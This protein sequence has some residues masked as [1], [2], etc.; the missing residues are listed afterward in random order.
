MRQ[1]NLRQFG[2][3][4][5]L[6]LSPPKEPGFWDQY[7]MFL[8]LAL[9]VDLFTPIL[10]YLGILPGSVRWLSD[11]AVAIMLG[12][13][14]LRMLVFDRI[15]WPA[16]IL[17]AISVIGIVMA[18]FE[19]QGVAATLW[20][21]W[22]MYRYPMIG[23]FAFLQP[24]WPE[25]LPKRL[26]NFCLAVL[27]LQ[28]V[29]QLFQYAVLGEIVG[30]NLAGTFGRRGVG[31]LLMFTLFVAALAFGDWIATNN[32]KAPML[33]L[34]LGSVSS[35]LAAQKFFPFAFI[36]IG[37]LAAA[38]HMI[39]SG[40]LQLLL[41]YVAAFMIIAVG[42]SNLYNRVVAE[43]RGTKTLEESIS[44]NALDRYLSSTGSR[45]DGNYRFGRNFALRLGWQNIQRDTP[46]LLF[47]MGIGARSS[48]V[49]LGLVGAGLQQSYYGLT[50]GTSL[51]VIMQETGLLGLALFVLYIVFIV[52]VMA[53]HIWRDPEHE[54]TPLRYALIIFTVYWP[55]WLWYH[56][57]WNFSV[58]MLLYWVTVAYVLAHPVK[59]KVRKEQAVLATELQWGKQ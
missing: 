33:V 56:Q 57:A 5:E 43:E 46:T 15:P 53:V 38:M 37:I 48:S 32:W 12:M 28:V 13:V 10:M 52:M 26:I 55:V 51:L 6:D 25:N 1:L 58:M 24:V 47:G 2:I 36:A 23:F 7:N 40:K 39:R 49:T 20:G 31:P 11:V 29:V 14:V 22:R 19:G 3:Q 18:L 34:V 16:I 59:E 27:A 45:S 44:F 35:T 54:A 30:D 8:L 41:V 42:F 21:W 4:F 17:L 50:S 9:A